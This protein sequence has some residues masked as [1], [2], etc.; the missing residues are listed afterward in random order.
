MQLQLEKWTFIHYSAVM[1]NQTS[2]TAEQVALFRAL[3]SARRTNRL[4]ADT[5][6][7]RFLPTGYRWLVRLATLPP[8]GRRIERYIDEHW[9]AG[10]RASAVVR[11]K[12]IDDLLIAALNQGTQQVVLLGAGYDSRAY[13]IPEMATTNVFEVDHPATQATKRRLIWAQIHPDQ[14]AQIRFVPVDL[15]RDDLGAALHEAAFVPLERTVVIWE[16][17]TNYLTAEA[18]DTTLRYVATTTG[19]GSQIIFTYIDKAALDGSG[20]FSGVEEWHTVVREAGEPWTFGFHPAELP[21]YLAE[22]GMKLTADL[23]ARDAATRYLTPLGRH[24]PTADF[25][26]IAHAEVL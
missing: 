9:P 13:R 16:G 7:V 26:R 12:L 4:F 19:R 17:V 15:V 8:L 6:A 1:Q 5:Y 22:R 18:V 2:R 10:P 11:T 20:T 14:H 24:E 3:E 25:Y 21:E 23:T